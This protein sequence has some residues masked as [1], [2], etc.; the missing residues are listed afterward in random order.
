[1][2]K[3]KH[4]SLQESTEN[5]SYIW[6]GFPSQ[7]TSAKIMLASCSQDRERICLENL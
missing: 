3:G 1:M 4:F 7:L 5:H 6:F 2:S